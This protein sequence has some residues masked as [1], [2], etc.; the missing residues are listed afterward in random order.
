MNLLSENAKKPLRELGKEIGLSVSGIRKRVEGLEKS[1]TIKG[2]TVMVDHKKL[3]LGLTAFACVD[4]DPKSVGG[5]ARVLVRRR[6]ICEV[7]RTTGEH[8]L[9]LKIRTKNVDSLNEFLGDV[10]SLNP[11]KE[12]QTIVAMETFKETP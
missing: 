3:G 11:V 7:H 4:V 12:V 8:S 10:S 9:M 5:L 2:Y 1:K 6:E